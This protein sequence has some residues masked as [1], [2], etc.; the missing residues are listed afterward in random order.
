[1]TTEQA[2]Q[3]LRSELG[4]GWPKCKPIPNH[5]VMR[6]CD[7]VWDNG[8]NPSTVYI[9][10]LLDVSW[11]AVRFGVMEWRRSKNLP[12]VFK[13]RQPPT[14][15]AI[16]DLHAALSPEIR[17]A[18]YTCFD[19]ANDGRWET[20]HVKLLLYL[21]K[22]RN[23]SVRDS[24]ALFAA[25]RADAPMASSYYA[26]V[27]LNRTLST[28]MP[29]LGLTDITEINP[30]DVLFRVYN[31]EVGKGLS[32]NL[33]HGIFRNWHRVRRAFDEYTEKLSDQE[34][35]VM[36][37]F[38][39]RPVNDRIKLARLRYWVVKNEETQARVKS[40]TDLVHAQFYRIRFIAS[41]VEPGA[42]LV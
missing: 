33:S 10:A 42:A 16:S 30:D 29:E 22:I 40:K 34:V 8:G 3:N 39:L 36:R 37:R 28:V 32:E 18:R 4:E 11:D 21:P 23:Q 13:P 9:R 14:T 15:V 41:S 38:F 5:L 27:A 1:M 26:I 31:R 24:M 12:K 2:L 17:Q 25:I 20:P 6:L 19:P 7:T 35:A